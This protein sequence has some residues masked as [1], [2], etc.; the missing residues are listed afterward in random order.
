MF[1]EAGDL[2]GKKQIVV[3]GTTAGIVITI[4]KKGLEF[5][6]YY[7][8]FTGQAKYA[9]HSKN[10]LITWEDLE[11]I[12]TNIFKRKPRKKKKATKKKKTELANAAPVKAE[13]P[14]KKYLKS[15]PIVTLLGKKYYMDMD[16][17]ERRP[18]DN[19]E[20]V[21]NFEE[22]PAKKPS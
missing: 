20:Q 8:S 9:N 22:L 3:G 15:L 12:K 6:G 4:S 21:V 16:R 5:N 11:K 1:K 14:D 7:A 2:R 10:S 13:K 18:V 19:P 17:K